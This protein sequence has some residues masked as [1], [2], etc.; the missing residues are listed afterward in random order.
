MDLVIADAVHHGVE[1]RAVARVAALAGGDADDAAIVTDREG[2]AEVLFP[3]AEAD[4]LVVGGPVG[5]GVVAAMPDIDAA[6]AAHERLE[7]L[8]HRARPGRASP[9]VVAGLN[10]DVVVGEPRPPHVPARRVLR[11]RRRRDVHPEEPDRLEDAPDER[12]G[13]PPVVVAVAVHDEHAHGRLRGEDA[14]GR[15]HQQHGQQQ[16]D[17]EARSSS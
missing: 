1:P 3:P 17:L 10:D 7:V 12:G 9:E 11:G 2:H 14:H 8:P 4:H 16:T 15:R 5:K 13:E 6:T